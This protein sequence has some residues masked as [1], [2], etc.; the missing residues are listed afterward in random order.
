M[1]K[2]PKPFYIEIEGTSHMVRIVHYSHMSSK[3]SPLFNKYRVGK[4]IMKPLFWDSYEQEL[5]DDREKALALF[6]QYKKEL[7]EKVK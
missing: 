3:S 6:K 5:L 4:Y 7:K 2:L 1:R